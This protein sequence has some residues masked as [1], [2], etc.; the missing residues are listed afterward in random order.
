MP[1]MN[2]LTKGRLMWLVL[3]FAAMFFAAC[4][5]FGW[6]GAVGR[7]SGWTGLAQYQGQIPKQR[8]QAEVWLTL[9]MALPFL[10]ALFLWLGRQKPGKVPSAFEYGIRLGMSILGTLGFTLCL[11]LFELL[12]GKTDLH[13]N[14]Y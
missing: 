13:I 11:L 6:L 1:I 3:S 10:G 8:V 7:I 2:T 12:L 9:A 4:A 5:V 14:H